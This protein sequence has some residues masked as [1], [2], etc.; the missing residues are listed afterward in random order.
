MYRQKY[1]KELEK[2]KQNQEIS[3]K[4]ADLEEKLIRVNRLLN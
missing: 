3:N 4:V 2:G 1:L